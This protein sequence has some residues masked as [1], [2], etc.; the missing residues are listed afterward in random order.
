M[1]QGYV[2]RLGTWLVKRPHGAAKTEKPH[3]NDH[4]PGE[5]ES[6][7][8]PGAETP[9]EYDPRP[10]Q[11]GRNVQWVPASSVVINR[12]FEMAKVTSGDY[13]I[14]PGSGDGRM[15]ISAAKLG[16]RALGIEYNPKLVELARK[17][18]A[19]ESVSDRAAFV[20]GDLFQADFSMAT[21]VALFLREDINLALRPKILELRPGTRIVSNIFHMRDWEADE[22][23]EVQDKDYYFKNH[24]VYLWIVP[25]KAGGTWK[26]PIGEL[27]LDQKFQMISGG[28][29][30][31]SMTVAVSGR[32]TGDRIIFFAGET[33][34]TGR[35]EGDLIELEDGN[36][37]RV[38]GKRQETQGR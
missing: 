13:L 22:V 6:E 34:Y 14:D 32:M 29:R 24:T 8:H 18:A 23:V 30:S 21:V 3:L 17:N 27:K 37:V 16:A 4:L 2:K 25:A 31:D 10:G 36:G 35:V 7:L 28:L 9:S 38:N 5:K 11:P 20:Q 1:I 12:M 15:V 26:L 19:K 33:Q